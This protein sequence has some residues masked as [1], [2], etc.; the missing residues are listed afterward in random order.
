MSE[1]ISKDL[2]LLMCEQNSFDEVKA[3]LVAFRSDFTTTIEWNLP[4]KNVADKF[5]VRK[6]LLI[7]NDVLV[8]ETSF[9]TLVIVPARKLNKKEI[10][11]D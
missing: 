6:I 1:A 11:L 9:E 5:I 4:K 3:S 8:C 7:S 2:R 10:T